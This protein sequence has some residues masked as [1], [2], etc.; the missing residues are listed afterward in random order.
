MA[1]ISR[2]LERMEQ[3]AP[4]VA[5]QALYEGAGIMADEIRKGAASISTEPFHYERDGQRLPSPE[6]KEIVATDYIWGA[7]NGYRMLFCDRNFYL[8]IIQSIY[9]RYIAFEPVLVTG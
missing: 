2:L 9:K 1:E 7:G 8:N 6:E 3:Q 5:A 4:A